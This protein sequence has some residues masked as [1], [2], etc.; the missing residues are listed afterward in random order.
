MVNIGVLISGSGTN[1]QAIIDEIDRGRIKGRI[2]LVLSNR[3]DAYGLE[4]A[5]KAG[6]EALYIDKR[7]FNSEEEYNRKLIDELT[8]KEVELVVLAGYL[9][10]LSEEFIER[11]RGRIINIHP[12]LIPSFCGKG[13]YGDKVHQMVLDSGVK[14]TGATVHFVDEGT[15]TGPIVLQRAVEVKDD[16]TVESLKERVLKVEHEL[17]PEAIRLFCE[18]RLIIEGKKVRIKWE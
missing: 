18:N 8:K 16:D 7:A 12:S 4:R 14:I 1:L 9:K 3:K 15:D 13:C 11:Y 17:L 2:K 5:R 10:I 6:I